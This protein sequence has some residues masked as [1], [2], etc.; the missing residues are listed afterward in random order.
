MVA[1]GVGADRRPADSARSSAIL[2]VRTEQGLDLDQ[3]AQ[4]EIARATC[5]H[6]VDATPPLAAVVEQLA[7]TGQEDGDR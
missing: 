7:A 3:L 2:P 4:D 6:E 1:E 5:T